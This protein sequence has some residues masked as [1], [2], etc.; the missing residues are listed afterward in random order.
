MGEQVEDKI[1][2]VDMSNSEM[3]FDNLTILKEFSNIVN[4]VR[5]EF[6]YDFDYFII[7]KS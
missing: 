3:M 4:I 5:Y 6:F 7:L 1:G 2:D